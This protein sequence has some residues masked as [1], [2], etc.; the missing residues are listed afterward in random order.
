MP[1]KTM[2]RGVELSSALDRAP[3]LAPEKPDPAGIW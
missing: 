2:L 3:G 1:T